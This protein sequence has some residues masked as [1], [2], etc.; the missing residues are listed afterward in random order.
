[1]TDLQ[2]C[3]LIDDGLRSVSDGATHAAAELAKLRA[4]NGGLRYD[5][6]TAK[7]L[8]SYEKSVAASQIRY[9]TVGRDHYKSES[10]RLAEEKKIAEDLAAIFDEENQRLKATLKDSE[11]AFVDAIRKLKQSLA[12]QTGSLDYWA[13][14]YRETCAQLAEVEARNGSLCA[15][16]GWTLLAAVI[17]WLGFVFALFAWNASQ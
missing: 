15:N 13:K 7:N 2:A 16:N 12:S 10:E 4:D 14:Q 11:A 5:L 3:K 17:G 6:E 9:M 8:L 1:M